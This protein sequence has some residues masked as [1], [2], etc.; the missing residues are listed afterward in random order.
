MEW[1]NVTWFLTALGAV[2]VLLTRVRLGGGG[3][4][5]TGRASGAVGFS[6]T[7]VRIHTTGVLTLIAWVVALVTG[8]REI[9]LVGL[10]GWWLL[11]VVGLLL[12]ARWLP[13]GGKH[14]EDGHRRLGIRC[15]SLPPRS[16][17]HGGR[18]RLLHLD[19]AHR[20][21]LAY[22]PIQHRRQHAVRASSNAS[23]ERR[24]PAP[25]TRS[26][27]RPSS[28]AATGHAARSGIGN[29]ELASNCAEISRNRPA[30]F[31]DRGRGVRADGSPPG[32]ARSARPDRPAD[33]RTSLQDHRHQQLLE[34]EIELGGLRSAGDRVRGRARASGS[35]QAVSRA[36]PGAQV[37]RRGAR[38]QA[39]FGVDRS[40]GEAAQPAGGDQVDGGV[41]DGGAA[42]LAQRW[43]LRHAPHSTQPPL[44][45]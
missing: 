6:V 38:R 13:S 28:I 27:R 3:V 22:Q 35:T 5:G 8:R 29:A 45:M 21:P 15:R 18:R 4:E 26:Y 10:A 39:G 19:H 20:P 11:S 36:S 1:S 41:G 24:V 42:V 37:V 23:A 31:D 9:A 43:L 7:L 44:Q 30:A 40:M 16:R 33:P 17:R 2:V 14:A 32:T 25:A 12:L 34:I